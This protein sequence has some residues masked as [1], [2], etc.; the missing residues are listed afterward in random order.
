METYRVQMRA[1]YRMRDSVCTCEPSIKKNVVAIF[2][3]T[4][5]WWPATPLSHWSVPHLEEEHHRFRCRTVAGAAADLLITDK[6]NED[7]SSR[8]STQNHVNTQCLFWE[9]K[10]NTSRKRNKSVWVFKIKN[11]RDYL[12]EQ[13]RGQSIL[14]FYILILPVQTEIKIELL[15]WL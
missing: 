8:K 9:Q 3:G 12:C 5:E 7:N 15:S 13:L 11:H 14:S 4:W 6:W 10:K 2:Q 1:V